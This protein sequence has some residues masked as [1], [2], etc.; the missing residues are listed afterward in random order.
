MNFLQI[1]GPM[2]PKKRM[3]EDVPVRETLIRPRSFFLPGFWFHLEEICSFLT[4]YRLG[5]LV[6]YERTEF[7]DNNENIRHY[8]SYTLTKASILQVESLFAILRSVHLAFWYLSL[9]LLI[10]R[11]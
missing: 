1:G 3:T 5:H 8:F 7:T 6:S 10:H 11:S 9:Y 4:S 2:K